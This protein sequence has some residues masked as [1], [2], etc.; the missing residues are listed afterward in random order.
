MQILHPHLLSLFSH[1][2]LMRA[3][4]SSQF[5]PRSFQDA[6]GHFD[7]TMATLEPLINH[8]TN[9]CCPINP[10]FFTV[11]VIKF[12]WL[13]TQGIHYFD[14]ILDNY[15]C[16]YSGSERSNCHRSFDVRK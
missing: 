3:A 1:Q 2:R 12:W 11:F 10:S 15:V 13:G 8:I 16:R 5:F 7:T 6:S 9:L 4:E 14:L